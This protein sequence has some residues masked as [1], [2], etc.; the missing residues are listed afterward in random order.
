MPPQL[1]LL[2][3][4]IFVFFAFRSDRKRN[5]GETKGLF[6]PTLWYLVV[7][8]RPVGYWLGLWGVP[9]PGAS[10]DPTDGSLIDRIFFALLTVIGLSIL[11]R[12]GFKWGA[13]LRLNPWLTAFVV[14]MAISI[15][16]SQYPYVSFKRYIKVIG[17]IVMAMVVLTNGN[18]LDSI[19]TVLRRCLYIHLPMSIICIK[20]YRYMGV[21][22]E[23]DGHVEFWNGIATSKNTLGQ[24]SMLA[25]LYFSWEVLRHWREYGW[26]NIHILYLMM[27]LYLIKGSDAAISMTSVSVCLFALAVL[28][29]IQSLRFRPATLR[30]FVTIVFSC[31][32]AFVS[33]VLVH[34]VVMFSADSFFGHVISLFGR[35]ITLTDR[36]SIWSDAYAAA[37]GNP[38]LG[39]GFGGFWIGRMANIPWNARMT[40]VLGQ[41]HSGYVDTY[42][43]LGAVGAILLA[44]VIFTAL[45]RMLD[46]LADDF[47]F[48]CFRITLFL[49]ILFINV[50]ES[51]YL[52]GDHHLWFLLQVVLWK[53]PI[54]RS[55]KNAVSESKENVS[56][57]IARPPVQPASFGLARRLDSIL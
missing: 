47:D 14:Y 18:P 13:A 36:T 9:I 29:R 7:C 2:V 37:S 44:G 41:A 27:A 30:R 16:W 4:A 42:L 50:T 39:V 40:W 5:V 17:S 28:F 24:V 6:W 55:S 56:S 51:V 32:V 1:A 33:F 21:S 15:I 43:Q 10:N 54:T 49:T 46:S 31:T 35:D 12:R 45:P 57:D 19:F 11:S 23:W 20:Y 22:F 25:V 3:G 26:R 52:R 8:S 53:A 38:L 48:A 34:S